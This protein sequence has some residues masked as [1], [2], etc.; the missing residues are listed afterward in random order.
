LCGKLAL[1]KDYT[2][3]KTKWYISTLVIILAFLGVVSKQQNTIPNQEIVLQFVNTDVTSKH[4]LYAIENVKEQLQILG[5]DNIHV[6]DGDNGRLKITYYSKKDAASIKRILSNEKNL[7]LGAASHNR[8]ETE[9]PSKENNIGYNLDVYDIQDGN[10]SYFNSDG[11]VLETKSEEHSVFSS[12]LDLFIRN[13]KDK[14]ENSVRV[15]YKLYRSI[16]VLINNI[17]HKIPEVRAGPIALLG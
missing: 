13:T 9:F 17:P 4:A 2:R 16:A 7:E 3:M 10:D 5:A 1:K 14:Q 6:K 12:S 15:A 11:Y 8:D